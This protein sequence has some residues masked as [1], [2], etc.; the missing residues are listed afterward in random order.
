MWV[1][2]LSL[3]D[4]IGSGK[5]W[6]WL[7]HRDNRVSQLS[8]QYLQDL[9]E[10]KIIEWKKIVKNLLEA[11]MQSNLGALP[12][13]D[14]GIIKKYPTWQVSWWALA[15]FSGKKQGEHRLCIYF[16]SDCW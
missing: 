5:D 16:N 6:R 7:K 11:I 12:R 15:K 10:K 3:M 2:Y 4:D 9:H 1:F 8:T 13:C 14:W